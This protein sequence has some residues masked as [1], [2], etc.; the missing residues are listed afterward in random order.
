MFWVRIITGRLWDNVDANTR[1][2]LLAVLALCSPVAA[3][4]AYWIMHRC[5]PRK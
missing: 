4:I 1:E 5:D 2:V 3:A